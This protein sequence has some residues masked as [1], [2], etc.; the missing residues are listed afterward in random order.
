M[1]R[2]TIDTG[3]AAF[4]DPDEIRRILRRLADSLDEHAVHSSASGKVLDSNGNTC[5]EWEVDAP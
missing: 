4:E 5:G 1:F 3:N 2:L